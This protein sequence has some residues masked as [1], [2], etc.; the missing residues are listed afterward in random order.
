M[1]N[2][3]RG[4]LLDGHTG[5]GL[6]GGETKER[7]TGDS[8]G[9]GGDDPTIDGDGLFSHHLRVAVGLAPLELSRV[10]GPGLH[11]AP[12]L[13]GVLLAHADLVVEVKGD[14]RS[15]GV[16]DDHSVVLGLG[17]RARSLGVASLVLDVER[18]DILAYLSL[19][20]EL[21]GSG[22]ELAHLE[23]VVGPM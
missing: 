8:T 20:D 1:P 7:D 12:A 17:A 15:E 9:D 23:L 16:L 2:G 22:D 14:D 3:E 21:L 10:A 18:D 6:L 5:G 4:K 11:A 13:L 19:L